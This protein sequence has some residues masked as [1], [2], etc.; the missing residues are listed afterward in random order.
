MNRYPEGYPGDAIIDAANEAVQLRARLKRI[1]ELFSGGP[2]TACRTT[3]RDEPLL[4][5]A[6]IRVECVE[7]PME[8]LLEALGP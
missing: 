3:W 1:Q 6:T 8:D 2:D 5:G 7:V 4:A